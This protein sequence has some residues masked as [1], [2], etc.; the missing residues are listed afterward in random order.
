M[1]EQVTWNSWDF[2]NSLGVEGER[3]LIKEGTGFLSWWFPRGVP[4]STFGAGEKGEQVSQ[5]GN[6]AV[7]GPEL[8]GPLG[9][10]DSQ[11]REG[12]GSSLG[13]REGNRGQE[14]SPDPWSWWLSPPPHTHWVTW[15]SWEHVPLKLEKGQVA[16]EGGVTAAEGPWASWAKQSLD[17]PEGSIK[18]TLSSVSPR[19]GGD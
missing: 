13:R 12:L 2:S 9:K 19:A 17:S 10:V 6:G 16:K 5:R 1:A 14:V 15:P 11:D 3:W 4:P 7:I 8:L 18:Q